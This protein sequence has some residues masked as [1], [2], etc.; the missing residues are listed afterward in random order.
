MIR[1]TSLFELNL[2]NV[3]KLILFMADI[4]SSF[5]TASHVPE[6]HLF[7]SD[8]IIC[9]TCVIHV[10]PVMQIIPSFCLLQLLKLSVTKFP[11]MAAD[12]SICLIVLKTSENTY[13]EAIL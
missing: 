10:V 11:T 9:S 6:N 5:V 3:L 1:E 12:L 8:R 4:W 2:L 13:F 7:W